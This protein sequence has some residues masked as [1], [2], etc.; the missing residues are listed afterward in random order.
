M[1]V[2]LDI[3][4]TINIT[5]YQ[6]YYNEE[7][8][9]IDKQ[10]KNKEKIEMQKIKPSLPLKPENKRNKDNLALINQ[11]STDSQKDNPSDSCDCDV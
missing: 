6:L 11:N 3:I 2:P 4:L 1:W 9:K 10:L 7:Q 8:K 5:L